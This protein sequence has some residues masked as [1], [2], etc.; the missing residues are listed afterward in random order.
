MSLILS[1]YHAVLV[2]R[3]EIWQPSKKNNNLNQE[4]PHKIQP[5]GEVKDLGRIVL[6]FAEQ[7][8]EIIGDQRTFLEDLLWEKNGKRRNLRIHLKNR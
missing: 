8:Y 6:E 2:T 4:I 5:K 1:F 3:E 7:H